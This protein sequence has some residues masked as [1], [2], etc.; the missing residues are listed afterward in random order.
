MSEI[1]LKCYNEELGEKLTEA[2]V[3]LDYEELDI[4][5]SCGEVKPCI[6][7]YRRPWEKLIYRLFHR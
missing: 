2:D 3:I 1:C 5:E 6:I 7:R 4:C